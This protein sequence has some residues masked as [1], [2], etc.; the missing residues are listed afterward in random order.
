M[1]SQETPG[2]SESAAVSSPLRWC[3]IRVSTRSQGVAELS[4]LPPFR[5]GQAW[6]DSGR[7]TASY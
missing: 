5:C 7:N 2:A 1:S 4:A 6:A 3:E